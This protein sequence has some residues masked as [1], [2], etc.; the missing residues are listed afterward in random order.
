M[1]E[2]GLMGEEGMRLSRRHIESGLN[3]GDYLLLYSVLYCTYSVLP[4]L[5]GGTTV[6][7]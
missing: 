4:G 3:G 6:P 5:T 7:D 2:E 1:W